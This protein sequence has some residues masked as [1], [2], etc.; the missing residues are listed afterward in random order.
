MTIYV[1]EY[2]LRFQIAVHNALVVK[3]L[4]GKKNLSNIKSSLLLRQPLEAGKV[5]EQL[6]ASA[7]IHHQ[8]EFLL[9]N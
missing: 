4:H 5:V 7:K 2:V 8:I 1:K 3:I 6:S 9:L